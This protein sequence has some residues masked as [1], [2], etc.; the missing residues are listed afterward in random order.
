MSLANAQRDGFDRRL[1]NIRKGGMNTMGEVHIGPRD[2]VRAGQKGKAK[3]TVR[4]KKKKS[5][6]SATVGEGSTPVLMMLGLLFGA[7]SMFVGQAAA[8]HLFE[9]GGLMQ[10]TLP[11]AAVVA[12]PIAHYI[13]G[14]TLALLFAW[15]F[16][17]TTVMRM[18][19]VVA[20]VYAMV[21]FHTDLVVKVPG[22]YANFFT[23]AYVEDMLAKA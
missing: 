16:R 5:V 12:T 10:L 11:E 1:S 22:L 6:K 21:H 7:M 14:G 8:F 23:E 19:A 3:N 17:L 15:T 13:I 20:G 4:M 2:E 9:V 18:M